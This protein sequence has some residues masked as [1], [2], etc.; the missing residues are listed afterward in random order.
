M[1]IALMAAG[2]QAKIATATKKASEVG[3]PCA[4]L[5]T[6]KTE[7]LSW[8]ASQ[9]KFSIQF[10]FQRIQGQNVKK[11]IAVVG[12]ALLVM[13]VLAATDQQEK[14]KLATLPRQKKD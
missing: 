7:V 8:Y 9:A 1:T 2:N 4:W 6:Q 13:P 3:L 5:P 11:I 14:Q 10:T 12:F